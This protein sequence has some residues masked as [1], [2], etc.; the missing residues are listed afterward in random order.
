V[1][2]ATRLVGAGTPALDPS[3]SAHGVVRDLSQ[4]DFGARGV[5]VSPDGGLGR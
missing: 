2:V 1:L 3:E 5:N 4:A